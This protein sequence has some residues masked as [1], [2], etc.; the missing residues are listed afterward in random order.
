MERTLPLVKALGE[1][2]FPRSIDDVAAP[3]V[4]ERAACTLVCFPIPGLADFN[5]RSVDACSGRNDNEMPIGI[6]NSGRNDAV[7]VN[8]GAGEIIG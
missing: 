7:N 3:E 2:E 1:Y 8:S 6:R 5:G 4:T